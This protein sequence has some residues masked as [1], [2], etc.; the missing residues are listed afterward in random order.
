MSRGVV[1][2][3]FIA[4]FGGCQSEPAPRP[5]AEVSRSQK[6]SIVSPGA[7]S[8]IAA[9][10]VD[11]LVTADPCGVRVSAI[12]GKLLMYYAIHRRLPAELQE[13][14]ELADPDEAMEFTCPTS[15]LPY[16]Y[17]PSGMRFAGKDERLVL[18]DA[19][20][21]HD[22]S[23]WGVLAAP[24]KGARPATTWAVRL[25]ED[26]FQAYTKPEAPVEE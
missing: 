25:P 10:E 5:R 9:K 12:A 2:L 13:L 8:P 16:V 22:G 7:Q 26:V 24:P 18:H 1:A 4:A 23:R 6:V 17:V 3:I 20:P 14:G 15:G 19:E 21:S 11:A